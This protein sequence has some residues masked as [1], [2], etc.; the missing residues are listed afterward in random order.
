MNLSSERLVIRSLVE[1]ASLIRAKQ[2][3]P[4]EVMAAHLEQIEQ[5]NPDLN[6][7]VTLA[8]DALE[9]AR[10]AEADVLK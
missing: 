4:V 8:P 7:I 1:T 6:A 9:R 5:L 10:L 3:S 2:V